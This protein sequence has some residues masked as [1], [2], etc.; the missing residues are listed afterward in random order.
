MYVYVCVKT[1][2]VNEPDILIPQ[3][4]YIE[5]LLYRIKSIKKVIRFFNFF[6]GFLEKWY[7]KI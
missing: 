3:A 5:T 6:N 4:L 7:S 1:G 2:C